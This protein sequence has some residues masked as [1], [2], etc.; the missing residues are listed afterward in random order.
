MNATGNYATHEME[1]CCQPNSVNHA[2]ADALQMLASHCRKIVAQ[3]EQIPLEQAAGRTLAK[4]VCLDRSEPPVSRSAMDGYAVLLGDGINSRQIVA[5]NY[6]GDTGNLHLE[7]GH[8]IKVMTGAS[9]PLNAEAVVM[10]EHC[11]VIDDQLQID[12]LPSKSNIR[13]IGE[14]A[15]KGD[16]AVVAGQLLGAGEIAAIASCGVSQPTV[17]CRPRVAILSTGDEIVAY[18]GV[19]SNHQSRDSN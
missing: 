7:P 10:V 19:V 1:S 8:A 14:M 5:V 16:V 12:K 11:Q 18:D 13:D 3:T 2:Y 15:Q 6:A 4:N 9:V 17:Y